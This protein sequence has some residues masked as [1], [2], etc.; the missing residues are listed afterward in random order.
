MLDGMLLK[1]SLG[2]SKIGG[3][4]NLSLPPIATCR[5]GAPCANICY[6]KHAYNRWPNVKKAW[7][8]NLSLYLEDPD[9]F[10]HDLCL[11]LAVG[12][13][14][15]F[16]LFVGGDFPDEMFFVKSMDIFSTYKDISIL[17]FTKR[18]EYVNNN[19]DDIPDNV[20]L[21]ISAWP[22]LEV[23]DLVRVLPSAW[24]QGDER[25]FDWF[26]ESPYV[27]CPGNCDTCGHQCW[28]AVSPELPVIFK[29][30]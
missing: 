12:N 23:P 14:R 1:I 4:P 18:Y 6:A 13:Y 11:F 20:N 3:V 7:D 16:R 8:S 28:H 24:L 9:K 17:C 26:P 5:P 10:W 30:H 25:F 15:R 29:Q 22:G 19:L 27:N 2:N 21:V